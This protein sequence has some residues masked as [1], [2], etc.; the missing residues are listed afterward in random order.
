MPARCVESITSHQTL[1]QND[2]CINRLTGT[3]RSTILEQMSH[4]DR[5]NFSQHVW[6]YKS[7]TLKKT[8]TP[9]WGSKIWCPTKTSCLWPLK[10]TSQ[11]SRGLDL[12]DRSTASL[13]P[14]FG[15]YREIAQNLGKPRKKWTPHVRSSSVKPS[16]FQLSQGSYRTLVFI[17]GCF[18]TPVEHT[19]GNPPK[20][21]WKKSLFSLLVKGLGVCSKGVL[22]KP[23]I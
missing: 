9:N 11:N 17:E 22:K 21:L 13:P 10:F 4:T 7:E 20:Q 15:N 18:N 16:T 14:G 3:T 1:F 2:R 12:I 6:F 23:L 5:R 8:A 19:P